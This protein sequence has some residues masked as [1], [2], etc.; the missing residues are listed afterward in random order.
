[1]FQRCDLALVIQGGGKRM[2]SRRA[3]IAIAQLLGAI[4]PHMHWHTGR[5]R[6]ARR[7]HGHFKA[8]LAP[9]AATEIGR[10]D[11][12]FFGL[13]ANGFGHNVAR[14]PLHLGRNPETG[15][16][17]AHIRQGGLRFQRGLHSKGRA[18]FTT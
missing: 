3:E 18:I 13:Q 2:V 9:K 5:F 4:P 11:F 16:V 6:Q 14:A 12:D 15:A 10:N 1:M 8:S 7:F 17:A